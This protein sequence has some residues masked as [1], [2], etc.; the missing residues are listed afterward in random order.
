MSQR[1]V[2]E[3]FVRHLE[4]SQDNPRPTDAQIKALE[5]GGLGNA[6][7]AAL[8]DRANPLITTV[9]QILD[10][11]SGGQDSAQAAITP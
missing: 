6:I 10:K 11:L 1:E 8:K 9:A 5:N 7:K 3:A 4:N 2:V